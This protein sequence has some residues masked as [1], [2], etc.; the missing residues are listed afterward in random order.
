MKEKNLPLERLVFFSDA[1]VAIAI[2]LLALDLRIEP[3]KDRHLHFAD[4][5]SQGQHFAA[6]ILSFLM[7]AIFQNMIWDYVALRKGY[8]MKKPRQKPFMIFALPVMSP[9]STHYWQLAFVLSAL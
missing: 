7:I 4:I 5:F 2:T 9:W 8:R 6:F 3:T 1:A